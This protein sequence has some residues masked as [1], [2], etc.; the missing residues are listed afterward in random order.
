[1]RSSRF[2]HVASWSG[3]PAHPKEAEI[4][5]LLVEGLTNTA[6]RRRLFV[7]ERTVARIRAAAGIPPTP[8]S[9][10]AVPR[11]P[12]ERNIR[13]LLD[14]GYS[15]AA[16]GRRTGADVAAIARMRTEGGFGKSTIRTQAPYVHL[17]PSR[18]SRIPR[19]PVD[20]RAARC[21]ASAHPASAC[22]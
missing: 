15:N 19:A 22:G 2:Q 17:L 9:A 8:R 18:S 3:R 6:I 11:H 14:E 4:R 1:M 16:I 5:A 20:R 13:R 12:Q 21:D 7:G 10:Y